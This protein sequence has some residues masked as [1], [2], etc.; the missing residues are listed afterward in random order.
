MNDLLVLAGI[1]AM[2]YGA[3]ALGGVAGVCLLLGAILALVGAIR[4]GRDA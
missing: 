1:V 2:L 3:W 4:S